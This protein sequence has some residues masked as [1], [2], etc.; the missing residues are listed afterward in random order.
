M[1]EW[2][3]KEVLVLILVRHGESIWNKK[4]LFTGWVDVPLSENGI[5][6]S[7]EVGKKIAQMPI[8]WVFTS[9]LIR[10]QMTA[11]F[12]LMQHASGRVPVM[13]HEGKEGEW[14]QIYSEEQKQKIFPISYH[15][16]LNER[17]YGQLQGMNKQEMREKFGNEQVHRWRRS[18]DEAPPKG[19]SL[20]MTIKRTLPYFQREIAPRVEKG[21]HVL[22]AAHGNS[23]RGIVMELEKL[24]PDEVVHLEI[25]TGEALF[26]QFASGRWEKKKDV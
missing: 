10:A 9:T 26:Y 22:V 19:E 17:M 4:N 6:E 12:V 3:E 21:E 23:L 25:A 20:A 14:G 11:V 7:I 1:I 16:A 24:K 8:D 18:Y 2:A 5:K 15:S 13:L